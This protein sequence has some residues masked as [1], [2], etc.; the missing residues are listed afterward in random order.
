MIDLVKT[1]DRRQ[2]LKILKSPR[3]EATLLQT[4]SRCKPGFSDFEDSAKGRHQI[5]IHGGAGRCS[6][7]HSTC[8]LFTPWARSADQQR[9]AYRWQE[10][11][12]SIGFGSTV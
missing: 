11:I 2:F 5:R 8:C 3:L 7:L 9:V 4:G 12:I 10:Q 1:E 6:Q